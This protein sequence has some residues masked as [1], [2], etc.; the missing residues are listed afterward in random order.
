MLGRKQELSVC[1]SQLEARLKTIQA[2]EAINNIEVDDTK[3]SHVENMIKQLNH[4]LDVRES[5]LETEGNVLGR[6]PVEEETE[7]I[8]ADV[9]TQIDSHFGLASDETVAEADHSSL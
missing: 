7:A 2:T 9:V 3:L 1:V 5:L 4:D 6:I 8:H